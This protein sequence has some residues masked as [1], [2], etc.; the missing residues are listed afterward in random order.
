MTTKKSDMSIEQYLEYS[1]KS[2][3]RQIRILARMVMRL[4]TRGNADQSYARFLIDQELDI[5]RRDT[6]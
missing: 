6:K 4:R 1:A 3:V 5:I 2:S